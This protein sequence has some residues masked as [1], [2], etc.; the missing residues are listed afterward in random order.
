L[1]HGGGAEHG[2]AGGHHP[3]A[4]TRSDDGRIDDAVRVSALA[5]IVVVVIVVG[6]D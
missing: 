4:L 5:V 6:F 3:N 2:E 1:K